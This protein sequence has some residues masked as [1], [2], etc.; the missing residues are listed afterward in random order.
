M[1]CQHSVSLAVTL[2]TDRPPSLQVTSVTTSM[3]SLPLEPDG[4]EEPLEALDEPE[5]LDAELVELEEL[6]EPDELD[7]DAA[8]EPDRLLPELV[9]LD[10]LDSCEPELASDEPD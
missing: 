10:P 8:D 6:D 1:A 5:E 3:Q 2:V 7:D 9:W 4:L